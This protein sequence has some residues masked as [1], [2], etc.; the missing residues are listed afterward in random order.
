MP[1]SKTPDFYNIESLL[2]EDER[3]VRDAVARFVDDRVLPIIA[4]CFEKER[5]PSELVPEMAELGLFGPTFTDYGCA[6]L[7]NVCYGL[8]MQ[9]LE[10]GDS[11]IRSF[12]SVQSGLCMFPIHAYGSDEQKNRW[13]PAMA[14][15]EA[16]G[17]FGLTEPDGGSDPGK[18]KT[19]AVKRGGDW[20][21]NG[22]KMWITSGTIADVAIVWAAT[23][24]GMRGFLV[25]KGTPGYTSRDIPHKMS[26]RASITSE[27][28]FENCKIPLENQLPKAEGLGAPL[29]CLTQARYGIAW[30][31]IGAAMACY[32]EAIEFCRERVLFGEALIHKQA[33]QVRLAEIVRRITLAQ[34]MALQLGRLKDK[35]EMHH[36]HVSMAKWN[37]VRMAIDIAREARD[38]L[39]AGGVSVECC[40]IRHSMNLES[41][42]TYEG[43]ETIHQ[44]IVAREL[45][46]VATF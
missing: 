8:I 16:I 9:E 3:Q 27:L 10:R 23:D 5:F 29:G 14:K 7:N 40:P 36:T 46:G 15:A 37:N 11:G 28:F 43:T 45:T 2:T 32:Q 42:I 35:G 4:E 21:L 30:G 6:G 13:L 39:G 44:L 1:N 34:L 41:V 31:G 12:A 24:D 38:I 20:V 25:E 33:M 19:N 17:C 26:L 22:A 18:M